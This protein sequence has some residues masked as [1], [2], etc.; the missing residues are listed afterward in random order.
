MGSTSVS[1]VIQLNQMQEKLT[2]NESIITLG[3][4]QGIANM[5]YAVVMMNNT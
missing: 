4:D 1:P 2:M 5:G 3:V